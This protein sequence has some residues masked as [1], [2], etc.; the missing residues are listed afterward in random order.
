MRARATRFR[1]GPA[2]EQ[3]SAYFFLT[4]PFFAFFAGA[5]AGFFAGALAG[6]FAGALPGFFA[7]GLGGCFLSG[8]VGLN[9]EQ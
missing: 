6:F 7:G 3:P 8:T 2:S 4:L 9:T 1:C 5:L